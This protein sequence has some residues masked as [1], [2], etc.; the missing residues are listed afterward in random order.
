MR[1]M[2]SAPLHMHVHVQGK[3][4]RFFAICAEPGAYIAVFYMD[5]KFLS[6]SPGVERIFVVGGP[7]LCRCSLELYVS[8][9]VALQ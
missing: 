3:G 8:N 5:D 6:S 9:Y 1:L 4:C 7:A 2:F